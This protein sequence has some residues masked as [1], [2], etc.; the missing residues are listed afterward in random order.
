M[1]DQKIL[2]ICSVDNF[3]QYTRRATIE[4]IGF[5]NG[6]TTVACIRSFWKRKTAGMSSDA[7]KLIYFYYFFPRK[8][9]LESSFFNYL[10]YYLNKF[11]VN[12][13]SDLFDLV[14]YTFP[15]Q[16]HLL[17][18]YKTQKKVF[19]LSDPYHLM[20]QKKEEEAAIIGSVDL[21]FAT[22]KALATSYVPRYFGQ[23]RAKIIYWP[24]C[25]DLSIWDR[26]IFDKIS[27]R[28]KLENRSVNVGFAGNFMKIT[29]FDLLDKVTTNLP[30]VNFILAGK[31]E[32]DLGQSDREL[33]QK[34]FAK[35]NV[36]Y[37]GLIPYKELQQEIYGWDIGIMI[38]KVSEISSYHHHNKF[39]QYLALGLP[40]VYQNNHHDYDGSEQIAF[41]ATGADDFVQ[42]LREAI[43]ILRTNKFNEAECL[44]Y[45]KKN[46]SEVR[47][48]TFL[49]AISI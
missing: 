18:F 33:L 26:S 38:D 40:V 39:Y 10:N 35:K 46:R 44:S 41:G 20:K 11:F 19:I 34:V 30:E 36:D 24:N 5:L 3:Q 21:I 32:P 14:C 2:F 45:A 42:R 49:N 4:A 25:V 16:S 1:T 13:H 9:L 12:G 28:K 15:T 43:A 37:K 8:L 27:H 22:A 31:V 29:D 6:K 7:V 23:G 48:E 47:A 17:P